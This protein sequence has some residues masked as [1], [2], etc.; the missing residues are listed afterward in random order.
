[1]KK[2][3]Q[4]LLLLDIPAMDDNLVP[5]VRERQPVDPLPVHR[6]PLQQRR[7]QGRGHV[8]WLR[9]GFGWEAGPAGEAEHG[10]CFEE[11]G[12]EVYGLGGG[13]QVEWAVPVAGLHW[14][15]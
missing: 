12:E 11:C 2:I 6:R 8:R 1:M 5:R 15:G 10:S 4:N 9:F 13:G 7:L 3:P 14:L